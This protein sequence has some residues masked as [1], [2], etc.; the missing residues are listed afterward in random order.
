MN[1]LSEQGCINLSVVHGAVLPSSVFSTNLPQLL[2]RAANYPTGIIFVTDNNKHN[3]LSYRDLLEAAECILQGLRQ[4]GLQPQDRV[5]LQLQPRYFFICLWG[6]FLGGFVPV[7]VGVELNSDRHKLRQAKDLCHAALVITDHEITG[8]AT[9]QV[10]DLLNSDRDRHWH[11]GDLDDLALLL[12]TSGSTGKSKGV[13]LSARNL[14]ASV[15]GM[16]TVNHLAQ[17][18]VT[19]NWMPLEHVASLVMFHLTEVYLGCQQIQVKREIILQDTLQWLNLIHQYRVTATW[20]PN[21]AYN[22]VNEKLRQSSNTVKSVKLNWDLSCLRWMGNG[23]EA[24]VGKTTERFLELLAPFGLAPQVI[25]PGYGMTE[26]TSGIV[27]SQDFYLNLQREFVSVG[28][29]I[30]GVSLRIV[31]EEHQVISDG[32]IG[33]L[34]VKGE[35]ITAGYYQQ[36]ELNE[37]IFTDDGWFDTGDLGFLESG[38]LT[39]TGRHKEV[40]IINGVNYYNHEIESVV[41]A[42]AGVIISY[43]AVCGVIDSNQQE[44]IAVFFH[45]DYQANELRALVKTIR[46]SIFTQI[47]VTPT[48]I[49]PVPPETIPKTAIGKIMRSQLS[50]RFAAGEFESVIAQ[51]EELFNQRSLSQQELPSN[52]IEQ[53]LVKVWQEVLQLN[54]VGVKDNFFELGGNSLLLMQVLSKLTPEYELSAVL[55]FQYPTIAALAN[56]LHSDQESIALQ[57]GKL[58]GLHRKARGNKDVAII[59]MSCRFPGANN[60][61]EFWSNLCHGVESIRFFSDQEIIDSGVDPE[62]VKNPNYVKASPILD[63]IENFDA[64]FWGYSPKEAQLLDPQQRLFME[65]A[66]ESLEDAGYDPLNYQGEIGLYG[67]AATNTYLLNNIYPHRHQIDPQ[68]DLQVINLSSM[69]GFQ[70]STANDKDYLTTRTSYKLNLRGFSVNVQT[71]CSTSLVTV[72]LACQSLINGESDMALAGGVSVHSPQKMGYLYQE[73]MILSSDGHC[74]A[75]DAEASGTIFG[76]GAGMVVLKL[77]DKAIEDGDRIYGIIKGSAVNND[78]GTKVGYFAPNVDGQTRVIAEAIAYADISPQSV[79][80]IEAHGTGTKLGDPIE[81]KALSQAYH[82]DTR[83]SDCALGSV[84]TN[85]GHLQMASGIVGLIKTT[86]CLYHQKIPASLHFNQPNPQINFAVSPFYINTCL[87]DWK[88]DAYPRRAGVNSLGIGG[89]NAHVILE[90]FVEQNHHNTSLPAYLLTLSAKSK[91]ALQA[92]VASYQ[93]YLQSN[94]ASLKDICL[95]SNIGRHHF[96]Y[97]QGIIAQDK[98]ELI[99]KLATISIK[100][101]IQD[102]KLAFLFTGQG[103][104]YVGMARQLYDTC[105][106]FKESCD[107][108][109]S[110]C[111]T[112]GANGR[113]PLQWEMPLWDFDINQ[114]QYVQPLLFIIEYSLAQLWLSWGIKPDVM[115]G[116]SIGEYVAATIAEVFSLEDALKLVCA[117]GKLMQSL[118]KNGAMTAVFSSK[119]QIDHLLDNKISIAADNG[120]HLVLSGLKNDIEQISQQL[121]NLS[122]KTKLLEVSHAFHSPLMQPIIEEFKVVAESINYAL[123]E[124]PIISNLTGELANET[125]ATADYWIEHILQPVQFAKSI[126]YLANQEVDIFLEVGTKPTLITMTQSILGK[127]ISRNALTL[128]DRLFL[129]SLHP[130]QPDW[131]NILENL[132]QLYTAGY[133]IDWQAVTQN[134]NAHKISLPTYPFQR[135][136]YWFD[137][138]EKVIH[139][140]TI[141]NLIHPLL[142]KLIDSPLKQTIFQAYLQP[143][144]LNWLKDHCLENKIIFPGTAY[145]EIAIAL[146]LFHDQSSQ[147][148]IKDIHLNFPLYFENN[149]K[150]EREIQTISSRQQESWDWEVHSANDGEW[151][152]HCSGTVSCLNMAIVGKSLA[153]IQT[154]LKD[155]ELDVQQHYLACEQNRIN[156]GKSFQGIKQLWAKENQALGLIELPNHLNSEAYHFHPALLDACLQILFVALP[157]ELQ[158]ITYLPIGLE[159]LAIQSFPGTKVWSYLELG[160]DHNQQQILIADV[161][162]Y[163]DSGELIAKIEGLKS[164]AIQSNPAWHSWLYQPQWKPQPLLAPA[165]L[166]S[167]GTWLIFADSSDLGKQLTIQLETQQQQCYLVPRDAIVNNPQAFVDL[168]QKHP[169]VIGVIYLWSLDSTENWQECQ[170]YLYLVQALIQSATHPGFWFVTRNAQ[171]VNHDQLMPG[172]SNSCL[173]GMQKAIALEHPELRCVGIDIDSL[174][175]AAA[176]IF[177]ELCESKIEQVA[178]RNSQRYVS[179]LARIV[180]ANGRSPTNRKRKAENLQLHIDNPGNLDSLQWQSVKRQQPQD[181]EIEIEVKAT[182]LNFRDVMVALDLYPDQTK[183]LGLECAGIVTQLGKDV[184]SFKIGD[185]VMAI[186]Q[187]SL[188]GYLV[189]DSRLAII[190]PPSFSLLEAATIPV[191]FLTAYY[192]L[193]YVAKLQP[194]EKVLIHAAAGGVGLAAIQIAQSIG[195]EIYATASTCKWS[196]L[197]S[198]G[199]KQIMNSRSLNF[200]EE[201]MS[202]T[203]GKGVDVVLNSLSG[204]FIAKSMAVLNDQGRF[205]EIGKQD[206]WSLDKVAQVAPSINYSIVDLWQITQDKPEL[207]QQMLRELHSKLHKRSQFMTEILKPLPYTVFT[208]EQTIDAFRYMQQGKHQGKIIIAMNSR[209]YSRITPTH[210]ITPAH[211][212]YTGTYLITGGMGAIGLQVAQWLVT[213]GVTN[214]VLLGRNDI[215]PELKDDLEKLQQSGHVNLIKADIANT[216]QLSQ[217]LIQI[218]SELPPLRGVVHCAGVTSDRT[219]TYQDWHSFEQVLAP[220]V[221][222]ALNL[223]HLTQKYNLESFILFSSAS[224]LIGSAGQ[225][226]YCAANAFLDSLAHVRRNLGLPAIS[227]NWSAWE[228]TGLAANTQ[229][230]VALKQKGIGSIKPHQGIE[231]LEQLLLD[232]PPQVGV[233]PINWDLWSQNNSVTPY[234]EDLVTVKIRSTKNHDHKQ[235]LFAVIPEHRESLLKKQ[236]SQQV[237]T[238]LGIKDLSKID[239]NLGF[240]ES[241]LDSLGSVELRNKLQSSYDL[242]LSPTVIFDYPNITALSNY[243]SSLLFNHVPIKKERDIEINNNLLNIENLSESQAEALLLEELNNLDL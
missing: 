112:V 31:N 153:E 46:R 220:K 226:N 198:M 187:N 183:F 25:S 87:Q 22:L 109:L 55:L 138:P 177:Q 50:Q 76:S 52:G 61:H 154:S 91:T 18:D 192:T 92:L 23:A 33:L 130:Q 239:L 193:V 241:G 51:V 201:I 67:G 97:R 139:H 157:R 48:Y 28:A 15:Y 178:Y 242:K 219:I 150:F 10:E 63:D 75:F 148:V 2:E 68:D 171:P 71:A 77:L 114:T 133:E 116:H 13:M 62:L 217:V 172:I 1:N 234:Y 208:Q 35:T 185:E 229:I 237:A 174:G 209:G 65:C 21:F 210:K 125:I 43:T 147:L 141:K 93:N 181:R 166:T 79:S 84:K 143:E 175:N 144:T 102:H 24:V 83:K 204:E 37:Q 5:I 231:I 228:H 184:T 203:N 20:S 131:Q 232:P 160:Q 218:E 98:Q 88:A 73:G 227:I 195:A 132:A 196:L 197:E 156:Y 70:V 135:Q 202:A 212:T 167:I 94:Q 142:G 45:T 32:S 190:K 243:L 44:Q 11:Q 223:H 127:G 170:S 4:R 42:I 57:Q 115:V 69:G 126:K 49:I 122:I 8:L 163:N 205:I 120:T 194:G 60:L 105:G 165:S 80:Y 224:S 106:V 159:K 211:Q 151:Q 58:R 189:V 164:Q 17:E 240:V 38:Q 85:V 137:L 41:E 168:I 121:D 26:T 40:I 95:T 188:S 66:W 27:H 145:L 34:Q 54:K 82:D 110:I 64:N 124:I 134:Y 36:P 136:R 53:R 216:N 128:G 14:L 59:G 113:S 90:E 16:A 214:F 108:C 152:L 155:S 19:L 99:E 199:V 29:P 72:H 103:S 111:N 235:Q 104:Q 180:G 140:Q 158:G 3:F 213:K 222:G 56:Y 215:K 221:Q 169:K 162:L 96:S 186:A 119:E 78:G 182:G 100:E 89:T 191:T 161:W 81:I 6:C 179:R 238:I 230:T 200:A 149:L 74:R 107:R 9:V 117:R 176:N 233:M 207:I 86:L 123:P 118:P 129:S 30:P 146:G 7:P 47:G 225:A 39:I 236:I 173:W 12:L 206:T 101:P